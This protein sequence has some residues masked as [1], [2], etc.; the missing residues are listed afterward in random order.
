M[1]NSVAVLRRTGPDRPLGEAGR[2]VVVALSFRVGVQGVRVALLEDGASQDPL[3]VDVTVDARADKDGRRGRR[4]GGEGGCTGD[5]RIERDV[6]PFCY[7]SLM[8][9]GGAS[10]LR[11]SHGS[12]SHESR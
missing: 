12:Y 1:Y 7:S 2:P 11:P 10:F 8:R 9:R 3:E 4:F 6:E 5:R